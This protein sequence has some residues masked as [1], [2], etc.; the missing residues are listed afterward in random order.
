MFNAPM[1]GRQHADVQ[2]GREHCQAQELWGH[3]T[4]LQGQCLRNW[5]FTKQ[6]LGVYIVWVF[7]FYGFITQ[8][9]AYSWRFPPFHIYF[10]FFVL[11]YH[12]YS[13]QHHF[14]CSH[15]TSLPYD[16]SI[17]TIYIPL[18]SRKLRFIEAIN[19]NM[20]WERRT[21]IKSVNWFV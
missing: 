4:H 19:L 21:M 18:Q 20:Q 5:C 14:F 15:S 12:S 11:S 8:K 6:Q 2:P 13:L 17:C 10:L 9:Q 7:D 3:Q 16:R 1:G